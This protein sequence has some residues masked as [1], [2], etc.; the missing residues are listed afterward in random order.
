MHWLALGTYDVD[1]HP[2]VGVLIEGLRAGGD[3]VAEANDP[4]PVD[5]A[6][7]VQMLEQPWRLPLLAVKLLRCWW[8]VGRRARHA[9]SLAH[10]DAILVG[11]LGHFD[12]HL[13]RLLFPRTPIV[14]DHLVSA[15]GTAGDRRLSPTAQLRRRLLSWVDSAAL[16]R[17]DVV[18]VDTAEHLE[19]LPD[20]VRDRGVVVPVG[21]SQ[22]WFDARSSPRD[23]ART[24]GGR[25]RVVFFGV[26]TP[27][28]GTPTM[29]AALAALGNEP[30]DIT[31]I[32]SGQDY[33][34]CRRLS[35]SNPHVDWV[36]WIPA[37]ELPAV[38]ARHDVCLGIFGTTP[39][40]LDV[41]PTKV[42]Q[43]AAA[44]CVV[45]TSDTSP[46]RAA[47]GDSAF[48]VPP[49]DPDAL[50]DALRALAADPTRVREMSARV[51]TRAHEAFRARVVAA[52]LRERIAPASAS[53]A[54]PEAIRT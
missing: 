31:V 1:R 35:A 11:Y 14:L 12:V 24:D 36:D 29:G 33:E 54:P 5:T 41:V 44:G 2:R 40:A 3:D 34:E 28:Q 16:A 7:R 8:H 18:V 38:V 4:L 25:L 21:A 43:G 50:A 13:A 52:R 17:S 27:L 48:L 9:A 46:Q 26:F 23:R 20:G 42:Y 39:K 53:P 10:P 32:G 6:A 15:A 45:V 51:R 49:G 19:A 30:I 22:A 37:D 47:F